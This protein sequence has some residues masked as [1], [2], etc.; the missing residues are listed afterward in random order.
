ML[1]K[2]RLITTFKCE[3]HCIGCCN[4]Y[5]PV[6]PIILKNENLKEYDEIYFT[7]GEPMLFP[8]KLIDLISEV[9][10]KKKYLYTAGTSQPEKLFEVLQL[11]DGLTYTI[12]TEEDV[13]DFIVFN[14][15]LMKNN[16]KKSLWLNVFNNI[17]IKI[18]SSNWN[19]RSKKWVINCPLPIGETL[20]QLEH[21]WE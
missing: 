13:D 14:N 5:L 12:H 4:N 2:L 15:I 16:I 19:I 21:L 20:G 17:E 7:G 9:E 10:N 11:L 8:D 1:K 6:A 18:S 3:R